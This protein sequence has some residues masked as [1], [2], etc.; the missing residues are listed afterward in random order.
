MQVLAGGKGNRVLQLRT[1]FGGGKTHTLIALYHLAHSRPGLDDEAWA[2]IPDPGTTRVAVIQGLALDPYAPRRDGGNT[3]HTLWGEIAWQVAGPEGYKLVEAQDK[4]RTAPGGD[5]LR[6]LLGGQPTLILMD[7]VLTYVQK[8]GGFPVLDS[9]LGRQTMAFMQTLTEVV[10]SLPHAALVYSLQA[11]VR[12]A[13]G[14]EALLDELDHLVSR[15]DAK[16]E[17]V[18]GDEILRVVQRRLFA[19]LGDARVRQEVAREYAALYRRSP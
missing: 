2:D 15:I 18:S 8:T 13:A 14:D 3:L 11:S 12:E 7:E 4:A 5:V 16:R 17:P 19:D 6:A 1:P 9:T 10:R